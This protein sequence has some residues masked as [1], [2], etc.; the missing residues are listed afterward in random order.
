MRIL[1]GLLDMKGWRGVEGDVRDECQGHADR[2]EA[3]LGVDW[4]EGFE[5]AEN[6]GVREAAQEESQRTMGSVKNM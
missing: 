6:E 3:P 2:A 4:L 1:V 5:E